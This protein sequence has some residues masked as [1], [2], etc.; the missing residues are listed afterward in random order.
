MWFT[1][2]FKTKKQLFKSV[3]LMLSWVLSTMTSKKVQLKT[4][5]GAIIGTTSKKGSIFE[6]H[7]DEAQVRESSRNCRVVS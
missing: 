3:T 5:D 2:T 4:A 6:K 1:D 7:V